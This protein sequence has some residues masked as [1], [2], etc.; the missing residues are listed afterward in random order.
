VIV[1]GLFLLLHMVLDDDPQQLVQRL[2]Q[3]LNLLKGTPHHA[4]HA[5]SL[6]DHTDQLHQVVFDCYHM[7]VY[8]CMFVCMCVYEV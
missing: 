1:S 3:R 7:Y 5:S 6:S 2:Y 8:V 4:A